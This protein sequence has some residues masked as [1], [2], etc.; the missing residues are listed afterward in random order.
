MTLPLVLLPGMMCDARLFG[1]QIAA[2]GAD[3]DVRVPGLT[4]ADSIAALAEAAEARPVRR[5]AIMIRCIVRLLLRLFVPITALPQNAPEPPPFQRRWR[6]SVPEAQTIHP[7]FPQ[8]FTF[9]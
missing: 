1:P 2:F 3:R 9:R 8:L 4:G 6:R 7:V 5:A